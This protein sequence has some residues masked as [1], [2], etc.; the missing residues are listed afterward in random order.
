MISAESAARALGLLRDPTHFKWYVIPLL[1][2]VVYV[3]AEQVR[4]RRWPVVLGGLAFWFMD[5]INEIWNGLVFHFTQYAPV[6][7]APGDTA[8][9][10][11]IGLNVEI[12]LMFAVMGVSSLLLLPADP[13]LR[14]LGINNR[15]FFAALNSALAV[16]VECWLNAIGALTWEY[17]YW[18]RGFPYLVFV[19]GYLPFFLVAYWVHDLPDTRQQL[20]AVAAL[21]GVVAASLLLFGGLLGWL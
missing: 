20:K 17:R 11:L 2:I 8:Y 5:W 10:I 9:L 6:W 21:G 4:A 3:Y 13:R 19:I 14:I 7:G 12:C 15:L 18:N 16:A 1:L